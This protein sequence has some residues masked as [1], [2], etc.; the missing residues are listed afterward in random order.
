VP[1][2][3]SRF[4]QGKVRGPALEPFGTTRGSF[5][6]RTG[7]AIHAP[8]IVSFGLNDQSCVSRRKAVSNA[9]NPAVDDREIDLLIRQSPVLDQKVIDL[10]V[11]GANGQRGPLVHYFSVSHRQHALQPLGSQPLGRPRIG[12]GKYAGSLAVASGAVFVQVRLTWLEDIA[13]AWRF[14]GA[15]GRAWSVVAVT[16]FEYGDIPAP[17]ST[18]IRYK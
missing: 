3:A 5:S 16:S 11:G 15:A 12:K 17:V 18:R 8:H 14:V 9:G 1:F 7:G 6:A 13:V 4:D 10:R 2:L